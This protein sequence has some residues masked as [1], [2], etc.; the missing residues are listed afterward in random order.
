MLELKRFRVIPLS[1]VTR[2]GQQRVDLVYESSA[3]AHLMLEVFREEKRIAGVP[4]ALPGGSGR[5]CVLLPEQE[6]DFQADWVLKYEGREVARVRQHW[7]K[8]RKRTM[9]VM[10]SS[11]TDIGLHDSQYIQKYASVR[12][13]DQVMQRCDETEDRAEEDRY[14]YTMEGTWFWNNY[15]Q[16]RGEAA[17]REVVG[18]YLKTGKIG[19]CCSIAGNHY[20]NFGL[21][22]L[23]RSAY[24]RR[25]LLERWGVDSRTM[26]MIDINGIPMSIIQPYAQAGVE[27]IIFAPNHWNPLP[28][29]VWPMDMD[30]EG[31]YLNPDAGGGG[32]RIDVRYASPL[33]MVF[34][35]EGE[36]GSRLLV[37]AS[38]QYGYGGASVGLFP[39]RPF[40]PESLP[41][42]EKRMG[43]HLPILDEKYPY[44]VWLLCCYDDDQAPNLE[45]TNTIA[46]WNAKWAWPRLRTLGDP[47]EPFRLLRE[48]HEA[49]IPVLRGDITGGWYQHPITAAELLSEKMEADRLLPTAEKWSSVASVL[50]EAYR[51]PGEEF[52]RAWDHLLFHDEHSYGTSGYQGRRVYETWMQHRDWIQK[53]RAVAGGETRKAL[54]SIAGK[55][56][57]KEERLALFNPTALD[58]REMV[59]TRNQAGAVVE[60]PA[61]GYRT[62]DPRELMPLAPV[63]AP[64]ETPPVIENSFYRVA[65]AENGSIRSLWDKALNR[66]LLDRK[67]PFRCNELCYT[68]D[69]HGSFH[70]PQVAAF[71]VT[72]DAL[73]QRVCIHTKQ[74]ALGAELRQTVTLPNHEKRIDID[75]RIL[76]AK[77][78]VNRNRYYRYLYFA[79][80]FLVENSRRYC[81]LNGTVAEYAVDVTGH[82]TDVYMAASEWCC[83]ENEDH[84]VAL[85]MLDSQLME[86]DHIHPDKTDFGDPGAGSQMFAY[87]A[88][89]WLQMHLAGG[90][91]LDYRFRYT[92]ASYSG[93]WQDARIPQMAERLTNPLQP[94]V[95]FPGAGPLPPDSHSFLT[96]AQDQRFLTL[97]RAEDGHGLI[98]RFYG[99]GPVGLRTTLPG[100]PTVRPVSIDEAEIRENFGEKGFSTYRLESPAL[101]VPQ[102]PPQELSGEPD[103]PAAVGSVYTGLITEPCAAPGAEDGL[104]YLL[105]GRSREEDFSHYL[106]YRSET[107]GFTAGEDTL[108]ARVDQEEYCVG[109]YVDR[110]LKTHTP[111]YYRVCAVN[112]GGKKG[113]LSREFSAFTREPL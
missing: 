52:R 60:V 79:F 72:R 18:R 63:S 84:G 76:H 15:G 34:F 41:L 21:E 111:Y 47:D 89:D 95:L 82:G 36:G 65:F 69:N 91:H 20:Q 61:F 94:A 29:T 105:W 33:P 78:M 50:E 77:D 40:T 30:K 96:A 88:T 103:A 80:P 85:L 59:R 57:A 5:V 31:C 71:T 49:Q 44:N 28:S 12:T 42:M 87:V 51:Y 19:I 46:A 67:N 112:T 7:S 11:H 92:I 13:L 55:I 10:L 66:E 8:P 75:N 45:V 37:W 113:P 24:E 102:G 2:E 86:F 101:C 110:G 3:A 9:Y 106:L 62:L 39:N 25:R 99:H 56:P 93:S 108:L 83:A 27:N 58:R 98:A 107:S 6:A 64:S 4:V 32:S 97:K 48:H 38:T 16:E 43:E 70:V 54:E 26:A 1:M 17:A 53:A 23:C 104:L 73:G 68:A 90:S 22:E 109:R 100:N 74:E 35:W 81:H 14:R